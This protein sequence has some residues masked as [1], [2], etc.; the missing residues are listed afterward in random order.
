M[1]TPIAMTRVWYGDQRWEVSTI[2][3]ESSAALAH[4]AEYAETIVWELDADGKRGRIVGQAEAAP[5]EIYAH[6]RMVERL[7]LAGTCDNDEDEGE[8]GN[9]QRAE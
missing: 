6:Q 4:G 9:A 1:G 8:H 3:R 2:N 7:H 5:G